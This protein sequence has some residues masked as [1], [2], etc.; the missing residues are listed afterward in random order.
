MLLFLVSVVGL[1]MLCV[2]TSADQGVPAH[3][4]GSPEFQ[5]LAARSL[6][7]SGDASRLLHVMAKAKRGEKMVVGMIGG[8]ITEGALASAPDKCWAAL[9]AQWWR[10]TFPKARIEFIN[11]GIGAT[12]SDIGA[13]R[14]YRHLLKYNPDFVVAEYAVNDEI[15]PAC[16][17]TLEGLVRQVLKMPNQPALMLLFTMKSKGESVQELHTKIGLHYGLPMVS[18][19]NAI[20]P[21]FRSGAMKPEQLIA[22]GIHPNDLGH[23]YNAGFVITFLQHELDRLSRCSK[24]P[25]ISPVPKPLTTD[26]FEHTAML[27]A[28]DLTP[29]VS[30]GWKKS[31]A[32]RFETRAWESSVP[33]STIKFEVECST[34]TL[35]YYRIR[36]YMG[37]AEARV[38]DRDPVK[39]D[40]WMEPT[41]GGYSAASIL[42]KDLPHG[43]HKIRVTVSDT[44]DDLSTGH[45][46][47]L[48]SVML[49][50]CRASEDR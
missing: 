49:A 3:D 13:H 16:V 41:W 1:A 39:L 37:I 34:V 47:V 12:G 4:Y 9:V 35:V 25:A 8:S 2:G 45:K 23:W 15:N 50:G 28:D 33:G 17:E 27:G 48:Q 31:D 20:L 19:R 38:D 24:L 6:V 26:A 21:E 11:A 18:F 14:A 22:D 40:G 43:K 42:A 5:K 36:G 44:K 46:F 30:K 7:S 32:T 10:D 29:T